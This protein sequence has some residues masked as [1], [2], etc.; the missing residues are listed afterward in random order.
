MNPVNL[1]SDA[2]TFV[3]AATKLAELLRTQ[4]RPDL[5]PWAFVAGGFAELANQRSDGSGP[6]Y[7]QFRA[8]TLHVGFERPDLAG[9]CVVHVCDTPAKTR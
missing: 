7:G 9:W 3:E 5:S 4:G 6:C 2:D 8:G 1:S